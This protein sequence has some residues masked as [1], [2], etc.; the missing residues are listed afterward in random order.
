MSRSNRSKSLV[1]VMTEP[2]PLPL[3]TLLAVDLA[4]FIKPIDGCLPRDIAGFL[5]A[6]DEVPSGMLFVMFNVVVDWLTNE[7]CGSVRSELSP[8]L[9]CI[10][11]LPAAPPDA[12]LLGPFVADFLI[13]L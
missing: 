7:F 6:L 2:V 11:V 3:R 9:F 13:L 8:S 4:M 12:W 5:I 1:D 10:V